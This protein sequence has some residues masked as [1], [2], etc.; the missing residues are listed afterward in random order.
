[1]NKQTFPT[2]LNIIGKTYKVSYIN[3]DIMGKSDKNKPLQLMGTCNNLAGKIRIKTKKY[4]NSEII[5]TLL[6]ESLHA[7]SARLSLDVTENQIDK[8]SIGMQSLLMDNPKLNRLL[9]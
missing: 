7:I 9:K 1:M 4:C 6:H 3:N 2:T 8:L 5:T